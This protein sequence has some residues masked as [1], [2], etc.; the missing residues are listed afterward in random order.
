MASIRKRIAD[1]IDDYLDDGDDDYS[2]LEESDVEDNTT[3]NE[4][5]IELTEKVRDILLDSP[6][7]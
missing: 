7:L 6:I 4:T 5:I 1:F 3:P 2:D